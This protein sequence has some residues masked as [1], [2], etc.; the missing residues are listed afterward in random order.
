[1]FTLPPGKIASKWEHKG[2]FTHVYVNIFSPD[3]EG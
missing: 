2:F 3:L 1:M